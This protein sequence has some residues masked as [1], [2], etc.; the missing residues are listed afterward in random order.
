MLSIEQLK[1]ILS[2]QRGM[3]LKKERGVERSVLGDI[4]EKL[5][6]PH[7]IVLSGMRRCGKST[8]L[9]QIIHKYYND[10]DFYYVS[11]EDERLINFESSRFNDIY[12]A[13]IELFGKKK[14]FLLD[15]VQNVPK[16]ES[17]V[18]RFQDSGFKFIITGSNA[19]L[20][21]RELGTKL[22][23][24]HIDIV[25][26][27]FS[28]KEFLMFKNFSFEKNMIY[29]TEKRAAIKKHFEEYLVQGGMPEYLTYE[30]KEVLTR[31]YEDIVIKDIAARYGVEDVAQMREL[32]K[33]LITNFSG[34]FSLNSLKRLLNF[35]SVNTIKKFISYLEETYL[36]NVI[37]KFDYSL[38]K[39]I[40]NDKKLYVADNGFIPLLTAKTTKDRGRMLEN[41]VLNKLDEKHEVFYYN[42]KGECDFV[43]LE[44]NKL[45]LAVQVCW[46]LDEKNKEREINGLSECMSELKLGKGL[47]L[48]YDQEDEF[49]VKGKR[50]TVKPVW[51]WLL[52][53]K[54]SSR[55]GL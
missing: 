53:K 31:T 23:G 4:G 48:T 18:R 40:A 47:V 42:N 9:R 41:L 16:F 54:N 55:A 37:S 26:R 49:K 32:Y 52:E 33:Y 45:V 6:L 17:F 44:K 29:K 50:I 27:P 12:E 15:E 35:G 21:S 20:L 22:T 2:E 28:F 51:K 36:V 7:V 25:V 34:R 10:E 13:L 30:D 46:E 5:K 19:K 43:L 8:L 11:F 14:T 1:Q 24:R 3:I 38:K 39:R